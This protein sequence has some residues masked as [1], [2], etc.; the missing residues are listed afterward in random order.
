MEAF[1]KISLL[2]ALLMN[3]I[4]LMPTMPCKPKQ[5]ENSKKV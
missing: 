3:F 5:E 2:S 4:T 1:R